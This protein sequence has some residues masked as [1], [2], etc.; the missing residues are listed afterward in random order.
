MVFEFYNYFSY[1]IVVLVVF[2]DG[3]I[4]LC[5]FYRDDVI[6]FDFERRGF[7]VY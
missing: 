2:R 1:G 5:C 6:F 7:F 4:G 3:G